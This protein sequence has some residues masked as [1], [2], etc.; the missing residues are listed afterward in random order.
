MDNPNS[1]TPDSSSVCEKIRL[2]Q[3]SPPAFQFRRYFDEAAMAELITNVQQH[4]IL[5]PI[6]VR[7]LRENQYELVTGQRRYKAAKAV[8]LTELPVVV[9]P[10]RRPEAMQYALI[11]NLQREDLN[12]VEETEGILQL[13][14]FRL[15]TDRSFVI[16]LLNRM[17]NHSRGLTDNVIRK[18]EREAISSVFQS[19][20]RLSP[21]SFRTNRLPLLNLPGEILE[22]IRRGQ[23]EYTKAKA[24]SKVKEEKLRDALLTEAIGQSLSLREI[25]DRIK[26]EQ[27]PDFQEELQARMEA[28]P[29]KMKKLKV[30]DDPEKR[31]KVE[32]LLTQMEMLLSE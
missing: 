22:A 19:L 10:M 13:L 5:Q 29:K 7:P 21:E 24:L 9:R 23:I 14:E 27:K 11:E 6:L 16:S 26:S 20:G 12:P 28:I 2:D 18:E 31:E 3:I 4:G 32:A 25:R 1:Q 15:N 17:A 30:W 8:G